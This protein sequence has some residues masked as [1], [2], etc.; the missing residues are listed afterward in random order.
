M[1]Q[2]LGHGIKRRRNEN[3]ST[4][5]VV[6]FDRT[7][8]ITLNSDAVRVTRTKFALGEKLVEGTKL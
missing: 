3:A 5:M 6:T 8:K 1:E 7:H 4:I 2:V